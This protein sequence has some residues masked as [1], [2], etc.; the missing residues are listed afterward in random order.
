MLVSLRIGHGHAEAAQCVHLPS[1]KPFSRTFLCL[2]S[3]A[4]SL[5]KHRNPCQDMC[6]MQCMLA[7][8][9]NSRQDCGSGSN[10]FCTSYCSS[11]SE[12]VSAAISGMWMTELRCCR[13]GVN[14][15]WRVPAA[16]GG[17]VEAGALCPRQVCPVLKFPLEVRS[18]LHTETA[19]FI[20]S[21]GLMVAC[22]GHQHGFKVA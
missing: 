3:V 17:N 18:T 2:L 12:A 15:V 19:S 7:H 11:Q 20:S 9:S 13:A 22:R 21:R 1:S 10:G 4:C 14:D 16:S 8:C 6:H 5:W